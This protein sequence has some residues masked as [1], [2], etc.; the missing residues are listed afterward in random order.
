[1]TTYS[2]KLKSPK[3]QKKRLKILERDDF[4]C[5]YCQDSESPLHIHHKKYV[6]DDPWDTPDEFLITVCEICHELVES[7]KDIM[8]QW[9][10]DI[11]WIQL[12]CFNKNEEEK[13]K[14]VRIVKFTDDSRF[15]V[16]HY[17]DKIYQI[18]RF[19]QDAWDAF[20]KL[21]NNG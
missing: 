14:W 10:V 8:K 11:L 21:I 15:I 12:Y 20:V 1:M 18:P 13:N 16:F 7:L 6:G 5:Q 19:Q 2:E 3:W 4:T 9:S 17:K